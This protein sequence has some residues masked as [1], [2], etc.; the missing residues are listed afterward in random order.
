ML[1]TITALA[2]VCIALYLV[3]KVIRWK[4]Y[5]TTVR[6]IPIVSG[7]GRE[8]LYN[9]PPLLFFFKANFLFSNTKRQFEARKREATWSC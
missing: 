6:H 9:G 5:E 7:E 3:Q 8:I 2:I 4:R 1:T